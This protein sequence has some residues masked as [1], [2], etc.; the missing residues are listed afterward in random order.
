MKLLFYDQFLDSLIQLNKQTQKRV[1]DFQKKF[2]ENPKSAAINLES[3][4]NFKDK[5]LRTARIDQ[6]YRIIIKLMPNDEYYLMWVDNH[7][8]AMDWARNKRFDW[9]TQTQ[10]LQVYEELDVQDQTEEFVH[11]P[12]DDTS[13]GIG[14]YSEGQLREIGVP[15]HLLVRAQ[16]ITGFDVLEKYEGYLPDEVFERLFQLLDG[17]PIEG[18]IE[19]VKDGLASDEDASGSANNGRH[20]IE[21]TDDD[22]L[23]EAI[24]GTLEKWKYYLHPSQRAIVDGRFKGPMKVT[25]GAGTGKTVAAMHRLKRLH[26]QNATG[27]PILFTTF[28]RALTSNLA[29]QAK[30]WGMV[31]PDV[32]VMHLDGI[33]RQLGKQFG[34]LDDRVKTEFDGNFYHGILEDL[35]DQVVSRWDED[36][37]RREYEDVILFH[38]VTDL[39]GYLKVP[40]AGRGQPLT[41]RQRTEV[42]AVMEQLIERITAAGKMHRLEL[43]N[44]VSR[45]LKT[46]EIHPFCH[47]IADELQD[48]SNPELRLIRA[49]VEKKPDDLLLVG[50][51]MQEVY[52]RRVNFTKCGIEVRGKRSR[53]LKINY[54]T[55]EEIKRLAVSV[56]AS[57]K[58]EDFDGAE[59]SKAGYLSLFHGDRPR[60]E[61][62]RNRNAELAG[63]STRIES[64]L[65]EG[66]ALQSICVAARSRDPLKEVTRQLH[67][68]GWP[69]CKIEG[70][71]RTGDAKGIHIVTFHSIKGLEFKHVFLVDVN[72]R[73]APLIPSALRQVQ[74]TDTEYYEAHLRSER[75]LVYVAASRAMQKLYITGIGEPTT[76]LEIG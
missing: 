50:D 52:K 15:E 49:M 45:H 5:T 67:A 46:E 51:P 53:R 73:T 47:V 66:V 38:G 36:F 40:R 21:L 17:H 39:Q 4:H 69:Y 76:Y 13:T 19:E 31:A 33:A 58:Y 74:H 61:L 56:I 26:G 23:N 29:K 71:K 64:L 70:S 68:T 22:A 30:A 35:L 59:E 12:V 11:G 25:G 43:F 63:L 14:E 65:A 41:R 1:K 10:N 54:R 62:F 9:N 28:T 27:R 34:I 18:I 32:Q 3:I 2:R 7:D 44:R 48:F 6:K 24:T 75:S 37:L 16:S 20:F 57:C 8:E 72:S 42:W 55:T 60:Y